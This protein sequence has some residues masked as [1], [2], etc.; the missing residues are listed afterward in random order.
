MKKHVY[1]SMTLFFLEIIVD[2]L[3][4]RTHL[5]DVLLVLFQL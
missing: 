4:F 5:M 2:A 3:E 1:H